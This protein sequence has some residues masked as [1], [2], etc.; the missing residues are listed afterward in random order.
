MPA[1]E[2]RDEEPFDNESDISEPEHSEADSQDQRRGENGKR[3]PEDGQEKSALWYFEGAF[4]LAIDLVDFQEVPQP[5]GIKFHFSEA[6]YCNKVEQTAFQNHIYAGYKVKCTVRAEKL[7]KA[8]MHGR[9]G[10]FGGTTRSKY[11]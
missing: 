7:S 2:S 10:N 4:F 9:F 8:Q 3:Q 6:E 1:I 5:A 11:L